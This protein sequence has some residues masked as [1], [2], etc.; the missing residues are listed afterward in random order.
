MVTPHQKLFARLG[1]VQAVQL[2]TPFGFQENADE[3]TERI[4]SYFADSVGRD[5]DV[6]SLRSRA[7]AMADPAATARALLDLERADWIFAGPG[8]PSYALDQWTGLGVVEI[9]DATLVNGGAVV[10][11][12]AAALTL[13]EFTIPVY[14]VYKVGAEPTWLSGLD[15]FGRATGLRAAV[16]PHF[17]NAEGGTHDTR[18][19]YMGER[20]IQTLIEQLPDDA[21]VL[22]IDEHTGL[23]L[24]L[25]TG[26]I[27]IVG[28]GVVTIRTHSTATTFGVGAGLNLSKIA[29]LVGAAE[30]VVAAQ[31]VSSESDS[32]A[33]LGLLEAG[34]VSNAVAA[35]LA[36][37]ADPNVDDSVVARLIA[38]VGERAA[39][40]PVDT[41]SILAPYLDLIMELRT[42]ARSE[43]RFA[44]SD[45]I[46]DRLAAAGVTIRDTPDGP[47]WKIA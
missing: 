45:L 40:A 13:G 9:L 42:V 2:D 28:R 39:N 1:A 24:D 17:D 6:V 37:H 32:G 22:G 19:C 12:S 29:E 43:N 21:F 30:R 5:V 34:E 18:F 46:R 31:P 15:V 38:A 36:M 20:R 16:V 7:S 41:E 4:R 8:S 25:D 27:D 23:V 14:E 35:L 26:E 10:F 11:A 44:D 47:Q 3:L 33:V